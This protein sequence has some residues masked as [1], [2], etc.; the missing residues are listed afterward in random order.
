MVLGKPHNLFHH[1]IVLQL[2]LSITIDRATF[3][4]SLKRV[5]CLQE[6]VST[7]DLMT[8]IDHLTLRY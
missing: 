7:S 2:P 3:P 4:C 6:Y 8:F 5:T 1:P